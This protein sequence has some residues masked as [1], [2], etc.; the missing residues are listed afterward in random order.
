MAEAL[1]DEA[2]VLIRNLNEEKKFKGGV[3]KPRAFRCSNNDRIPRKPGEDVGL[4][5]T[6]REGDLLKDEVLPNYQRC[7]PIDRTNPGKGFVGLCF[8]HVGQ[9]LEVERRYPE[10]DP[11]SPRR[12]PIGEDEEGFNE[13]SDR[14]CL[15]HCPDEDQEVALAKFA[16]DNNAHIAILPA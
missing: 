7:N 15:M 8:I 5:V 1:T 10:A 16:T 4:S 3:V 12:D 14:H 6:A 13:Y 11:L 9:I 2:L